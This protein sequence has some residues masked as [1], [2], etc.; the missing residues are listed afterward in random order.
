MHKLVEKPD[1]SMES[2]IKTKPSAKKQSPLE[3]V[4]FIRERGLKASLKYT[5]KTQKNTPERKVI[6]RT[7]QNKDR[8]TPVRFPNLDS[9]K[10]ITETIKEVQVKPITKTEEVYPEFTSTQ[11]TSEG[12]FKKLE[13][14][15]KPLQVV[16]NVR[17][18]QKDVSLP[19]VTE[20]QK[21]P[22]KDSSYEQAAQLPPR[23]VGKMTP[24]PSVQHQQVIQAIK[25][26]YGN[27]RSPAKITNKMIIPIEENSLQPLMESDSEFKTPLPKK[28]R[29]ASKQDSPNKTTGI[30]N[31]FPMRI[32]FN[33][34]PKEYDD[35]LLPKKFQLVFD[36]FVELDNAINNCKRRGK[37]PVLSNLKPYIEQTTNR[38]FDID[39]FCKVYY[40][41]PEL[42]YCTWQPTQGV[43]NHELRIEIPEN[44]EEIVTKVHKK[45]INV[46]VQFSPFSEP[47]TNFLTNK[48]KIILRT[49][50][51]LYIESLHNN[52]LAFNNYKKNE[53]NAVKGWHPNFDIED[54]MDLPKK[55]IDILKKNKKSETISEFLKNK[56]IRH[57]LLKRA[58]EK[59]L[60]ESHIKT[61]IQPG[62]SSTMNS[63]NMHPSPEKRS[64]AKIT[65]ANIS[66]TF[67][68]RIET[69]E[70]MYQEEK[71][72]LE[73]ESKLGEKKR[74][75][76]LMLKISQAVKS[77]FSVK[78]KVST[79]F[80]NHVLKFL[81][82][83]QR[84]NFYTKK[85][86]I[87][88]LKEISE[89]VPE[90]LTLK[91]HDRGFLVK[92]C[93]KVN[94]STIR[95]KIINHVL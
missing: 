8:I 49:R 10:D 23:P 16:D 7:P 5:N 79:L 66:P 92:I 44:I 9:E 39:H 14:E 30:V 72:I 80:L 56:N 43:G 74:K 22:L 33:D 41:A 71:Q 60:G 70:K 85:E 18:Q 1:M 36:F 86:L 54:V 6:C 58:A 42:F 40:V 2:P 15:S 69:K 13:P 20:I 50:L 59:S 90:W 94:I 95:S 35:I 27:L 77:V 37:V 25:E 76:D 64:P 45:E 24:T 11:E 81:N 47:M 65:N 21:M 55:A 82:D 29:S 12:I 48:R 84:G 32:D 4:S 67:Y 78:G 51:I 73:R 83:S 19:L 46:K 93:K 63:S 52:F 3:I 31:T 89:I 28:P 34:R 88:T 62:S 91:Q 68:K 26:Q 61:E 87:S 17:Y 75:Q 38:T 57:T 53:Y